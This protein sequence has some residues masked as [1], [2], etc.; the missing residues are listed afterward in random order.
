[1]A[2]N[3]NISNDDDK[4][5]LVLSFIKSYIVSANKKLSELPV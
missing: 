4:N 1:M 5:K 3:D 2:K